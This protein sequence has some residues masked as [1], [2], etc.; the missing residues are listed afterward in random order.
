M[1][2]ILAGLFLI[3]A[4]ATAQRASFQG[5]G[6]LPGGEYESRATAVSADGNV[7]VGVG[8]SLNGLGDRRTEAFRW[9]AAGG[10][11][12]LGI[13]PGDG[14]HSWAENVSADGAVVVGSAT[15][16]GAEVAFRWTAAGG[17][18]GIGGGSRKAHGVSADGAVVVGT[19]IRIGGGMQAF[20]WTAAG[21]T[22]GLDA[23]PNGIPHLA[24]AVSADGTI[25]VGGGPGA[26]GYEAF[27][28]TAAG[29]IFSLGAIPGDSDF[30][31]ARGVSADGT[32][33]IGY[34][35]VNYGTRGGWDEAFRWTAAGGMVSIRGGGRS[36]AEAVSADG[37]VIV[38]SSSRDGVFLWTAARGAQSVHD[39][40]V[41]AG[42]NLRG[43]SLTSVSG[44]SA[45]GTVI[46]G[47][48][49]NPQGHSEA[50]RA[51]I[52]RRR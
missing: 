15:R 51:V 35:Y 20:R 5:L 8:E 40:L 14:D 1:R 29:G 31:E 38:G 25:I 48:G 23:L 41:S 34:G 4:P 22:V 52:P 3:A 13:L 43:W 44:I 39:L 28:W 9:T 47:A 7:V 19:G 32:V 26:I 49:G 24:N 50:W 2:L 21:G 37:A 27:R 46:V 12:G 45:D 6:D 16:G 18:V 30:S 11:V 33:V 42:V 36:R 17:M 10:M